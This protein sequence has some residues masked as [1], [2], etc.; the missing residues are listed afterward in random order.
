MPSRYDFSSPFMTA[1]IITAPGTPNEQ[2]YPLWVQGDLANPETLQPYKLTGLT[3]AQNT[4]G[5]IL[6]DSLAHLASVTV[7]MDLA[8]VPTIEVTLTPPLNDARKFIDST[9]IEYAISALEVQVGYSTGL[10]GK[11]SSPPF[12][13]IVQPPEVSFGTDVSI[14]MRAIGSVSYYLSATGDTG[15][16]Q[17]QTR[18]QHILNLVAAVGG[19]TNTTSWILDEASRRKLAEEVTLSN[20]GK[21]YMN[22]V[23]ELAK[24]CGC[25]L[26]LADRDGFNTIRLISQTKLVQQTPVAI[27]AFYDYSLG[28]LGPTV[29]EAGVYPILSVSLESQAGLFLGPWSKLLKSAAINKT[30]LETVSLEARPKDLAVSGNPSTDV[31]VKGPSNDLS[32]VNV[33]A[34]AN[35]TEDAQVA[36]NQQ[37]AQ[38]SN[39]NDIGL[40]LDI[41]TLGLPEVFPGLLFQV[42]GVSSRIDGYYVCFGVK[43]NVSAS[44]FTTT[45][46]L[47]QNSSA[48]TQVLQN[49]VSPSGPNDAAP[50][51]NG[52]DL[53]NDLS[54]LFDGITV[55]ATD[56]GNA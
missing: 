46:T 9:L 28:Q 49:K 38:H 3:G 24:E 31:G 48:M 42:T 53:A 47:V 15:V 54:P 55:T 13:G 23:Y 41:E 18:T 22:I 36:L 51:D 33:A 37:V 44:G 29:G 50:L 2:R 11:V 34:P 30:S 43:H 5:P 45:L 35:D 8:A 26:Q 25:W 14:S 1:T 56:Q 52:T 19:R 20:S 6:S 10:A 16:R 40:K 12:Q 39:T 17:A 7:S 27:L 21:S 32:A 4:P